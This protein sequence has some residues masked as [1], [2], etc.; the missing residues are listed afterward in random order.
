MRYVLAA[1]RYRM[2]G[3]AGAHTTGAH[4]YFVTPDHT[5]RAR[6]VLGPGPL[7][8]PEQ[9]VVVETDR[10]RARRIARAHTSVYLAQPNYV[11]NLRELGFSDED[12]TPPGGS[13]LLVDALVAWGD[14]DTVVGRVREHLDAG[15]DHVAVQVLSAEKRGVPDEQWRLLAAPLTE[16]TMP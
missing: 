4:P 2:L 8:C 13:D 6:D 16:L 9:A 10:D 7:L 15:A 3:L 14:V 11:N 12:L 5:V 1:L